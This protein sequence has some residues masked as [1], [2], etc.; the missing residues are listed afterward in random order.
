[1]NFE[2]ARRF[3]IE[4]SRPLELEIY[5]YFFEN[6]SKQSV[7]KELA[8]Y[9]NADG[10]FGQGLEPDN[11]NKN[12]NPI[13]TNDAII[14]LYRIGALEKSNEMIHSIVK[15]LQSHDSF[16]EK[17]KRW[18]LAIDSNKEFPHAI[19][20][21]KNDGDGINGFNPTVS[22]ATFMVCFG[23]NRVYYEEI[24]K[25]AFSFLLENEDMGGDDLKCFLLS[26]ELLRQNGIE[27][28]VDL[29]KIHQLLCTR[30]EKII[31]K[32]TEQYGVEYV[33][34]PSDFFAGMYKEIITKN[35]EE[36]IDIER[37][38]LPKIQKEDGGFDITWKWYTDY[39]EFEQARSWWR[40]R[41][42]IDKLLFWKGIFTN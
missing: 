30:I 15:Y 6:G 1:M 7:L 33:S 38:I 11:W 42:T 24:V 13:A 4:N 3:I 40:P 5:K 2:K 16:D 12:S 17:R 19:W 28:I 10:G 36:L 25:E 18:L 35:I 31:C 26:Y 21:E 9:Q 23:E 37:E 34:V 29:N 27:N 20:W 22:L 32:D 8:K 41:I 14:W 39:A